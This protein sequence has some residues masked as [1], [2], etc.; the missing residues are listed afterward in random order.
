MGGA[1]SLIGWRKKMRYGSVLTGNTD[2]SGGHIMERIGLTKRRTH[3]ILQY[4]IKK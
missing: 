2:K 4:K 1:N 3:M